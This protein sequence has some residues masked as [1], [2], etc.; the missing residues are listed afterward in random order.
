[1]VSAGGEP[2]EYE[3]RTNFLLYRGRLQRDVDIFVGV[4]EDLLRRASD[5]EYGWL[6]ARRKIT[7][8]QTVLLA[9]NLSIFF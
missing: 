8:D 4:R 1:M 2:G 6:I 5:A 7:L 3:V 9:K